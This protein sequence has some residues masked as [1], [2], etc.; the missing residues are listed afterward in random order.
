VRKALE[1][2]GLTNHRYDRHAS[3]VLEQRGHKRS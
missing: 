1:K 2:V 3:F